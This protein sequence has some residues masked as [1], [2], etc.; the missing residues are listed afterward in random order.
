MASSLIAV[1]KY[2]I[3]TN[4]QER[5]F[6]LTYNSKYNVHHHREV[7]AAADPH[8]VEKGKCCLV[9]YFHRPESHTENG[10]IHSGHNQSFMGVVRSSSPRCL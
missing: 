6:I 3:R 10:V 2:T 4:L 9:L 5:G 1:I 7:K 8:L